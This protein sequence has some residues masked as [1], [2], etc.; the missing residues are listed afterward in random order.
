M[1]EIIEE[2]PDQITAVRTEDLYR[3]LASAW[4]NTMPIRPTKSSI[5]LLVAQWAL[6]TGWGGSMHCFNVG[7]IKSSQKDGRCWTF[8]PCGE[9]L[10]E[11]TA[12]RMREAAPLLVVIRR[13]YKKEVDGKEISLASVYFRPK[14]PVTRFRAYRTARAGVLDYLMLIRNRFKA[15]WPAVLQ[16][17]PAGFSR[18]LKMAGYYTADEKEY[19]TALVGIHTKLRKVLEN[20]EFPALSAAEEAEIRALTAMSLDRMA[21]E[22]TDDDIIDDEKPPA[23]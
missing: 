13:V 17:N 2:L 8:F 18:A 16:A 19:S 1:Q 14:H 9:E 10:P 3:E 7:N 23:A 15:A 21:R 5:A 6:E 12:V 22:L 11:A 20:A 4:L